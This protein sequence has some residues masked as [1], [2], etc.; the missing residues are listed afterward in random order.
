MRGRRDVRC[1]LTATSLTTCD[2]TVRQ[3]N[4]EDF[5]K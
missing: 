4:K 5:S 2:T 3:I 1:V